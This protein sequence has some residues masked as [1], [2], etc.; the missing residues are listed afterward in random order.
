MKLKTL[1][2]FIL[3]D[4]VFSRG[5]IILNSN[6]HCIVYDNPQNYSTKIF[7]PIEKIGKYYDYTDLKTNKSL[8]IF[9]PQ[10]IK[11]SDEKN[12]TYKINETIWIGENFSIPIKNCNFILNSYYYSTKIEFYF[13][14]CNTKE[15]NLPTYYFLERIEV[16]TYYNQSEII[17]KPWEKISFY[18]DF[19]INFDSILLREKNSTIIKKNLT[20][21]KFKEKGIDDY[22]YDCIAEIS[23][24]IRDIIELSGNEYIMYKYMNDEKKICNI[25]NIIVY[26]YSKNIKFENEFNNEQYEIQQKEEEL[27]EK[28]RLERESKEEEEQRKKQKEEEE[29]A[30]KKRK[31]EACHS[32]TIIVILCIVGGLIV[33]GLCSYFCMKCC[34]SSSSSS[35]GGGFIGIIF[36][37]TTI[38]SSWNINL[39]SNKY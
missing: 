13:P 25:A 31:N 7:H 14:I 9:F 4:A 1:I 16:K 19:E 21:I 3:S 24:S 26:N 30:E 2:Y 17:Y 22:Y 11:L 29:E 23:L 36:S 33:L 38:S 39:L 8:H 12:N 10:Y 34:G 37:K 28:K 35:S 20:N 15:E 5:Y 32:I 6:R 18:V 27:Q